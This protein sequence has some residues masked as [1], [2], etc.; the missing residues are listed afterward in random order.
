MS[1]HKPIARKKSFA[2]AIRERIASN[3]QLGERIEEEHLAA[4]IATEIYVART[5][6][7]LTQKQLAERVGTTQSVIARLEDSDY[8]G[9]SLKMLRRIASALGRCMRIDFYQ[10]PQFQTISV[11]SA[12]IEWPEMPEWT[13]DASI[14]TS[15][16]QQ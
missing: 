13:Y 3:P 6:A 7:G 9:H 4:N 15:A 14:S 16:S 8:D 5:E 12:Q 10:R 2:D 1:G 11:V